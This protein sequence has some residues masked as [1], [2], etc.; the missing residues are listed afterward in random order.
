MF[1]PEQRKTIQGDI[2]EFEHNDMLIKGKVLPSETKGRI[3]VDIISMK[4]IAAISHRH[5]NTFGQH[6]R[7][8]VIKEPVDGFT[9]T[10]QLRRIFE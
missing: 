7:Y 10:Y 9:N 4:N 3:V 6:K 1:K 2:I 5:P 8:R